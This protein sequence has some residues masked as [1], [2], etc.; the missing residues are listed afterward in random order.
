MIRW[1]ERS[2]G[3]ELLMEKWQMK[4]KSEIWEW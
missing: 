4:R 2:S 3:G 1:E